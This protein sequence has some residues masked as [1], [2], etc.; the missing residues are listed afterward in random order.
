MDIS[1]AKRAAALAAL[2][3]VENLFTIGLGSG[4]TM[5]FF[6]SLLAER[7][8]KTKENIKAVPTS[9]QAQFL[10]CKYG[11]PM[12]N[13]QNINQIDITIDGADEID[14][15]GN[16]IK[17]KGGAQLLE[18]IIASLSCR[19]II[20][21][22]QSK[23]VDCLGICSPVPIE[24]MPPALRLVRRKLDSLGCRYNIRTGSGK[25]GPVI[26][27]LGNFIIDAKFES[28]EN[29]AKL[30]TDLNNIPGIAGHGLFVDMAHQALIAC[31]RDDSIQ[32]KTINFNR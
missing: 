26:T 1:K 12:L 3:L 17:G 15:N 7:L 25:V 6:T 23:L 28:I 29:P 20:I 5:E 27:D 32:I 11:I 13:P 19:L 9:Y 18:K 30:N 21:A 31:T 14:K 8:E 2:E 4:S 10:A 24:V 16:L 22:D